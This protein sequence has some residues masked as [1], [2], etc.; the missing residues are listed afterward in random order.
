METKEI[1]KQVEI[2]VEIKVEKQFEINIEKQVEIVE[3][4]DDIAIIES[5]EGSIF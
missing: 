3:K 4:K 1:E 2:K 5:H